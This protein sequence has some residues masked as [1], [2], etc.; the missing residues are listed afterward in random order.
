MEARDR[1]TYDFRK[2]NR[3]D[4]VQYN[5]Q[6]MFKGKANV[7]SDSQLTQLDKFLHGIRLGY[8]DQVAL[9]G[10]SPARREALRIYL[11]RQGLPIQIHANAEGKAGSASDTVQVVVERHVVTP[12]TCPNWSNFDGDNERNTPGSHYGC[13]V[14]ASL[15]Y[16]IANPKD[17]IEGQ[18]PGPALATPS[19][20]AQR[21]YQANKVK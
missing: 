18:E 12:P 2:G 21:R 5:H 10:S 11:E 16:M 9:Q 15:G 4:L 17:L 14:D 3:V 6:V 13:S 19:I 20:D 8:G 7:P 1:S